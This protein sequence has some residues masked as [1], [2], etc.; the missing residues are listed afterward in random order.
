MIMAP[1]G[2]SQD[3]HRHDRP[4]P[5]KIMA[6]PAMIKCLEDIAAVPTTDTSPQRPAKFMTDEIEKW[7]PG[8]EGER[9][10]DRVSA[11]PSR[12]G[13]RHSSGA[14]ER[15]DAPLESR[16]PRSSALGRRAPDLLEACGAAAARL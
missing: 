16:A 9:H 11:S 7:A 4:A 6:D 13:A 10:Q 2:V 1:A 5:K 3:G 8:H 15:Q 14:V 12:L